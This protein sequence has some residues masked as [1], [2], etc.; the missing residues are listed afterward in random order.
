MNDDSKAGPSA[1]LRR[2]KKSHMYAK[3]V[4]AHLSPFIR[5]FFLR[6]EADEAA[7]SYCRYHSARKQ[8][9]ERGKRYYREHIAPREGRA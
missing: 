8:A 1:V 2:L 5:K 4:Y 7:K 3:R 6:H 9:R